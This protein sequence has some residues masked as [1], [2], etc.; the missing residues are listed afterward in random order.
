MKYLLVVVASSGDSA[1]SKASK[2]LSTNSYLGVEVVAGEIKVLECVS[3]N[4]TSNG[5]ATGGVLVCI[6]GGR[7]FNARGGTSGIKS[8]LLDYLVILEARETEV[9]VGAC[10]GRCVNV[11]DTVDFFLVEG[12]RVVCKH[13][14]VFAAIFLHDKSPRAVKTLAND[15]R[16]I[17]ITIA[18]AHNLS[19]ELVI[20][21]GVKNSA[22]VA[23]VY[24]ILTDVVHRVVGVC[25]TTV[26][27]EQVI[28]GKG[29]ATNTTFTKLHAMLVLHGCKDQIAF[30]ERRGI[31]RVIQWDDTNTS[32]NDAICNGINRKHELPLEGYVDSQ[33]IERT[34]VGLGI[35]VPSA[36]SPIGWGIFAAFRQGFGVSKV[37]SAV[38]DSNSGQTMA[39]V[40]KYLQ[41][42]S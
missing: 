41:K 16:I 3:S 2:L 29:N 32:G 30:D 18:V 19:V 1:N 39:L 13:N 14:I 33:I 20:V 36:Q 31:I 35:S 8:I 25:T 38:L 9:F 28:S 42:K 40:I 10:S 37:H 12:M 5:T 6:G 17:Q 21:L 24:T 27:N 34:W 11:N 7:V 26:S 23:P 15:N 4:E 22:T